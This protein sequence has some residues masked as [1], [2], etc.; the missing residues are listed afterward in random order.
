MITKNIIITGLLWAICNI[1]AAQI[2]IKDFQNP[3]TDELSLKI[4]QYVNSYAE[5]GDFAGCVAIKQGDN[6]L[7]SDCFGSASVTFGIDNTLNH[8]FKIGSISKQI[9]AVAILILQEKGLLTLD[10]PL[11]DYYSSKSGFQNTT[12]KHLLTHQAGIM[13]IYDVDNFNTLSC[14]Q[15]TSGELVEMILS[16][17]LRFPSG[18]SYRYSNGGYLILADI[19]E[20]VSS[21]TYAEFLKNEIFEPLKMHQ[22]AHASDEEIITNLA[23]GYDPKGYDDF[24]EAAMVSNELMKGSGSLHSTIEDIYSW[25]EML[26]NRSFL[27]Q[28]SYDQFFYNYGNNYGLGISVYR[29]F[30][31][32]VFGHDGRMSGY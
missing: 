17:K 31:Q 4:G 8:K 16:E 6:V 28:Q 7:Y 23:V 3:P 9:T 32:H 30:D 12:I 29:F 13:D 10:D 2:N 21:S 1:T 25:I 18:T 26:K 15:T 24:E 14:N 20:K 19:I 27:S 5:T 11:T 22:T